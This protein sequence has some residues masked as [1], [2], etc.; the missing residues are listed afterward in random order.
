MSLSK[1]K[2]PPE[3]GMGHVRLHRYRSFIGIGTDIRN[4]GIGSSAYA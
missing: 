1:A 2:M 4:I 3:A